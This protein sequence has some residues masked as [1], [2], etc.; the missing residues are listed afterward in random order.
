MHQLLLYWHRLRALLSP[1]PAQSATAL[2]R[3]APAPF[4]LAP[5]RDLLLFVLVLACSN[6]ITYRLT[7]QQQAERE[8]PRP[9]Y[10]IEAARPY[11]KDLAG[12]EQKVRKTAYSLDVPPEWL[13]AVMY[14]ESKMNPAVMNQRG[15]GATGL[16]QFMA[17]AV[18][19]LNDRLGTAYYMSDIR[20]MSAANQLDLVEAYLRTVRGRYGEFGSLA[21][22]YLAVLYPKAIGKPGSYVLFARPKRAYQQNAGLDENRDGFV[23]VSDIRRR[24]ER[25]YPEAMQLEADPSWLDVV[26]RNAGRWIGLP[27]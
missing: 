13:M 9:L 18:R 24:M 17:P 15:S 10:L 21:D 4:R 27:G 16:I 20:Q 23:T 22:L 11:V 12:F 6:S 1:A 5:V 8:R 3:V 19:D 2:S 26:L 7:V 25:L 14:H